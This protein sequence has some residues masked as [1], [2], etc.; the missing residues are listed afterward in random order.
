MRYRVR[1]GS[2]SGNKFAAMKRV[3]HIYRQVEKLSLLYSVYCFAC[4]GFNA[5]FKRT[6]AW[7]LR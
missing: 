2:D 1:L 6:K 4:Y 5:V 7:V 3:W